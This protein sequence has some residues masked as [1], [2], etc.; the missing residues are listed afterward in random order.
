MSQNTVVL[1]RVMYMCI[2]LHKTDEECD[3]ME[4]VE[5]ETFHIWWTD[6]R[7]R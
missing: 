5:K 3:G 6:N 4:R 2:T 7:F 1:T